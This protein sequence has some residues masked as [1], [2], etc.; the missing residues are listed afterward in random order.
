VP[1]SVAF[2]GLL[3]A[4]FLGRRSRK[5]RGIAGLIVLAA[6]GLALTAC[7]SNATLSTT[8]SNP[9]KGTYTITVTGQDQTT[10][11]IEATSAFTFVIN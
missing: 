3:L 8:V 9:P 7:S 4:G 2:A 11:S 10:A 5:L 1:F 6:V